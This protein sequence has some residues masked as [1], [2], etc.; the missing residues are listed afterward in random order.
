MQKKGDIVF[1]YLILFILGIIVLVVVLI[2]FTK[3][4]DYMFEK[5]RFVL[6]SVIGMRPKGL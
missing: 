6:R 2:M 5:V 1:R 3:G 4:F